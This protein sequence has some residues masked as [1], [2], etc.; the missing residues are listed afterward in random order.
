[1]SDRPKDGGLGRFEFE[2]GQ[3]DRLRWDSIRIKSSSLGCAK[4]GVFVL[5]VD[6]EALDQR[7]VAFSGNP[8]GMGSGLLFIFNFLRLFFFFLV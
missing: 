4:P 8:S 6:C 2:V 3:L 5:S 1:M 7:L